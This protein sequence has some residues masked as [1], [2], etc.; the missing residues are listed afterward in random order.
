MPRMRQKKKWRDMVET[1][2]RCQ[3]SSGAH[4]ILYDYTQAGL[5]FGM[6]IQK[7]LQKSL[8]KMKSL[9]MKKKEQVKCQSGNGNSFTAVGFDNGGGGAKLIQCSPP[10]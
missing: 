1:Y 10:S 3:Q 9:F 5:L 2:D 4:H 8:K 6:E 7:T